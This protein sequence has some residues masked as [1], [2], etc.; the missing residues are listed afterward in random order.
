MWFD[1]I[2][3]KMSKLEYVFCLKEVMIEN[4]NLVA[5]RKYGIC[6]T[7]TD[8][9]ISVRKMNS[10]HPKTLRTSILGLLFYRENYYDFSKVTTFAESL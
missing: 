5:K 4:V 3:K 8:T 1:E 10:A 2:Y 9:Q 7:V 6:K